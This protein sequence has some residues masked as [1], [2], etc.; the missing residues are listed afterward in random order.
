MSDPAVYWSP[1]AA[2]GLEMRKTGLCV[3]CLHDLLI[4]AVSGY[5]RGLQQ[6]LAA[7]HRSSGLG[8]RDGYCLH[9]QPVAPSGTEVRGWVGVRVSYR[10]VSQ[11]SCFVRMRSCGVLNVAAALRGYALCGMCSSAYDWLTFRLRVPQCT[12]RR[13]PAARSRRF[14]GG[15]A[16]NWW[17]STPTQN[18]SRNGAESASGLGAVAAY[19]AGCIQLAEP[20]VDFACLTGARTW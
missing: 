15:A 3:C 14:I 8:R 7:K 6:E 17:T 9:F 4:T 1:R 11:R 5:P 20:C 18:P 10:Y 13:L 2:V 16:R 12:D 19:G